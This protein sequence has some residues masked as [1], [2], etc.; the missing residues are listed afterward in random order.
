MA[1]ENLIVRGKAH[2]AKLN[3][4]DQMSN[5]YQMDIGSLSAGMIEK[6]KLHNVKIKNKGDDRGDFVTA[7][8]QFEV[9]LWDK[10]NQAMDLKTNIGNGSDVKVRVT[11]NKNHPMVE[12]KG[13]AMYLQKVK[14]L[15]LVEYVDDFDDDDDD[16]EVVEERSELD[17]EVPF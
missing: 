11:F 12:E 4:V 6:L 2:W 7:R 16:D 13:T 8:S 9:V 15:N 17:D 5:K 1:K 3:R 14:V 10:N